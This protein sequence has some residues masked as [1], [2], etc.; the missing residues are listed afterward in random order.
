[1][2]RNLVVS[3]FV[4]ALLAGS[5]VTANAADVLEP[6]PAAPV[7]PMAMD[8]VTFDWTGIYVGGNIGYGF[9]GDDEVGYRDVVQPSPGTL[10]TDG[11]LGGLQA[12]Y[13]YQ[14]GSAVIGLEA[15]I[16]YAGLEDR[17]SANGNTAKGELDWYG[18]VRPRLGYA[19]DRTLVYGTG[20]LAYGSYDMTTTFGNSSE[21]YVGWVV[22]G[23]V[24]HAFTDNL[25]AKVE[26]QYVDL[27]S[28][29]VR[30]GGT[31]TTP[32]PNFHSVRVGLNYK[33]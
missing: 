9:A 28:D 15:D 16:Q 26:Y 14:I 22:G 24:E 1:M 32:S 29:D 20:G 5:A 19:F 4:A 21:T 25:T 17:V 11:F 33:F 7:A 27:G 12:G 13:N 6:I 18:T 31:V 10:E 3:G 2:N 8:P 23:G 30:L